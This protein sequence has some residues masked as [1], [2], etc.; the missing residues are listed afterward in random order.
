[1]QNAGHIAQAVRPD[2]YH[3]LTDSSPY[4]LLA[5]DYRGFG[6]STGAPSEQGLITDA[7]TAVE[8]A[9]GVAGVPT[10]RIVLVG[11]SLG[12]AVA[13]AVAERYAVKGVEFAGVVL[14]AG[15][16]DL[17]SMLSGYRMGGLVPLLGPFAGWPWFVR[18]MDRLVVDKWHSAN[19]LAS[20]VRHTKTRLRL[21]LVH[22]KDDWDIAWTEDNKLFRAAANETAGMLDD[23]EFAAWK[24]ERT[25]HKGKDAFVA[26][27]TAEPDIVIRQELFPHGGEGASWPGERS[28][29]DGVGHD[30]INA[31]APVSLAVMRSF[32]LHG[33]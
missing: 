25:V 11:H 29:A 14:V 22:A 6:H 2:T 4:H 23:D 1:M 18:L 7:S 5:I 21:S 33:A 16:G 8:W 17:A 13:S 12:T 24:E 31:F 20:L 15:F 32:G 28:G 9:V 19:R 27:W 10:S 26:T 30:A 3:A